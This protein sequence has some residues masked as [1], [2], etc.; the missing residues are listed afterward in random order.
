MIVLVIANF[1]GGTGKTTTTAFTSHVLHEQGRRVLVV[2]ADPQGSSLK[3][4]EQA[5]GGWPFPVIGMST[6]TLH[7][8]LPGITGS[9]EVIVIDTPPLEDQRGV[10]MSALR[11]ATHVLVPMAPS[12]I[13]YERLAA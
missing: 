9:H 13:E 12:P 10:V 7:R 6:K 1:K 5:P 8:D 4:N 3:W 2:D 11:L